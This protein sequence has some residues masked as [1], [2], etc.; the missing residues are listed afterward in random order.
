ME[1]NFREVLNHTPGG[2]RN[3]QGSRSQLIPFGVRLDFIDCIPG[4]MQL[5]LGGVFCFSF[6]APQVV[7]SRLLWLS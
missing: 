3:L 4:L 5:V 1:Q 7:F 6:T 2:C